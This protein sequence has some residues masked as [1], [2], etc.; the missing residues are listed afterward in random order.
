[1]LIIGEKEMKDDVVSVRNISDGDLGS[2]T[3]ETF[4]EKLSS[5]IKIVI[6]LK[7]NLKYLS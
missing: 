1:M 7:F 4:I 3:T 2:L 5:E 6:H